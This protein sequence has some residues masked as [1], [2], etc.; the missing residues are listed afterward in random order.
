[1]EVAGGLRFSPSAELDYFYVYR[2]LL[3]M[4]DLI[5][6]ANPTSPPPTH[7]RHTQDR[8]SK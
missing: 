3:E 1:M 4:D 8:L 6:A 5:E 7:H 2:V